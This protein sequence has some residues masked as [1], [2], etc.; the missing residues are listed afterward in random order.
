M[1]RLKIYQINGAAILSRLESSV[2]LLSNWL[3]HACLLHISQFH[4]E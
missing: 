1:F 2:K 3:I 4:L